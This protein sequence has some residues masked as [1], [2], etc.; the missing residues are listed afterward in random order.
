VGAGTCGEGGAVGVGDG[1]DDGQA[2]PVSFVVADP[3]GAA[4]D[5][6]L[7][8]PGEVHGFRRPEPPLAVGQGEQR[9]DQ[10][11]LPVAGS[12][13]LR[14][15]P[16]R[17]PCLAP[18]W[19]PAR[20]HHPTATSRSPPGPAWPRWPPTPPWPWAQ[21]RGWPGGETFAD[22]RYGADLACMGKPCHHMANG[23]DP[24]APN[25]GM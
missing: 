17:P 20:T 1:P 25:G 8:D 14:P 19:W 24:V 16:P 18:A 21:P 9:R 4:P 22:R 23:Q 3:L 6:F 7:G 10:A 11:L 15:S 12:P 13:R 2:E 5:R